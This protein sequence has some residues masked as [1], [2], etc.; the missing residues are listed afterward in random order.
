MY[1]PI[2]IQQGIQLGEGKQPITGPRIG[3][4]VS[5]IFGVNAPSFDKWKNNGKNDDTEKIKMV[6]SRQLSEV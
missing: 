3:G 4:V 6:Q 5:D 1:T 2:T